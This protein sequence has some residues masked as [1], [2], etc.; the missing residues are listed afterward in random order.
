MVLVPLS[1]NVYDRVCNVQSHDCIM[2]RML[3][4]LIAH[5]RCLR[6]EHA[7]NHVS[8]GVGFTVAAMADDEGDSSEESE[9]DWEDVE[10]LAIS[11]SGK[12]NLNALSKV[13]TPESRRYCA[14]VFCLCLCEQNRPWNNWKH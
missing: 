9:V 8:C 12:K 11:K 5:A 4:M 1:G 13:A 14:I 7:L 6:N 10:P 3:D 2:Y